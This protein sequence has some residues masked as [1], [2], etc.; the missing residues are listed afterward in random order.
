MSLSIDHSFALDNSCSGVGVIGWID[1]VNENSEGCLR[2]G[3]KFGPKSEC[4][5]NVVEVALILN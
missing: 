1:Q 4:A 2:C 3:L 5:V